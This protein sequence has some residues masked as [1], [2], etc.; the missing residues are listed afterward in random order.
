MA[1][2]EDIRLYSGDCLEMMKDIPDGS[3]DMVLCDLPYGATN[4]DW[5]ILIPFEPLWEHYHRVCKKNAAIVLFSQ[6]PFMIDL[7]N[8]NRREFRYEWIWKKRIATGFLNAKKIP[9]KVHENILVFYQKLPTYNP[10][11]TKAK[12]IISDRKAH[13]TQSTVY[14]KSDIYFWEETGDRFPVDIVEFRGDGK[15]FSHDDLNTHPT[16][17]PV[18][19]CEYLIRTYTNENEVVLDNTM[20]SGT[21]GVA[22]VNT[23]R[24]FIGIEKEQKYFDIA[25]RRIAEAEKT[26]SEM[27]F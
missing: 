23:D 15:R 8:S 20:G 4:C 12:K 14:R 5:D 10:Q 13:D 27:L 22:C 19:L 24:K 21:T 16:Q 6:L 26:R 1:L 9:L 17:K 11:K 7:I 2:N 3:V 18:D 25:T